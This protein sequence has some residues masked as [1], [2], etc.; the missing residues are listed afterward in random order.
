MYDRLLFPTDGSEIASAALEYALDVASAHEATLYVLNVADTARD[1]VTRIGDEVVDVLVDE[2]ERVVARA[3]ERADGRGVEVVTEVHQG[4]PRDAIVEYAEAIEADLILMPTHGRQGL[5]RFLLGS[6]TE[7]VVNTAPVPVLTLSPAE[8]GPFQYPPE[9]V[10]VATDGSRGAD[11]A[12]AEGIDV[13]T[14]TGAA[15]DVLHVVET[16]TFDVDL[17]DAGEAVR[18]RANELVEDAVE[19]ARE[20]SV[21]SVTGHVAGGDAYREILA[22]AEERDVD[23]V[24]VG[25]QGQTEFHRY[26]LGG[27]TAKIIRTSPVPVLLVRDEAAA[28]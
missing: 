7:G 19:R 17:G 28:G 9:R 21:S 15:L 13:A 5:Q 10:L 25:A 4:D 23:L 18:Q 1:S 14:E 26:V 6:V 2:G 27:V 11:R 22:Y 24:V 20:A 3:A 16:G 12:L 8:D